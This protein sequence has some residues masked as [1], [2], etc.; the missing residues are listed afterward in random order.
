MDLILFTILFLAFFLLGETLARFWQPA[1]SHGLERL[2]FHTLLGL[3][4]VSGVTTALAFAGL[5]YPVT[6]WIV[7]AVIFLASAKTW[8]LLWQEVSALRPGLG[9][10][11]GKEQ[12][13]REFLGFCGLVLAALVVLAL[14]L[15][16]APP[17]KTDALVYH[18]ALPKAYLENHGIINLP[19]S[20][21]SF[22]PLLFEMV[23]LFALTFG[24][25]SLPALCGLGM[26]FLLLL[27][28]MVY[29]RQY[30]SP[31]LAGFVP[32]L[33]F[34]TP[35]FFE[36]SASAYVDLAL[37]GFMFFTFYSW[38]RWRETRL[39]F[40]FFYMAGCAGAAWATKLT[41]L[42][43]LPLAVLGIALTGRADNNPTRVVKQIL[44]FGGI[45]F[46][47][48]AP[49]WM[50]NFLYSGNPLLPLLMPLLGGEDRVNWDAERALMFD[51]YV[52]LFGM[53]RGVWD[54][55][56]LP[57]NLTFH[58][59]PDSLKFDGRIGIVFFLLIPALIAGL[60]KPRSPRVA[61]LGVFAGVLLLFWFVYFQYVRFLAP[62]FTAL[63]L[64]CVAG[65][66]RATRPISPDDN[67]LSRVLKK[68]L[69]GMVAC[70]IL[71]NLSLIWETWHKK[72]P[73]LFVA[74][75]E[76]RDA[77]LSRNIPR[78]PMYQAMNGLDPKTKVLL[79]Y[80]RN[81][82]Y[83]AERPF[84]SDSVF[85]AHTLQAM[86]ARDASPEGLLG[87]FQSLG[88]T[89]LM[90]DRNFVF[91]KD[92]AFSPAGRSALNRFLEN[93]ARLVKQS[94]DFFLYRLVLD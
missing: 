94:G 42:I 65:L 33:F 82:G 6:G 30:L 35:T 34:C 16:L 39:P 78:Y 10:F 61:A 58:A 23:F 46:L 55:M 41:G 59:E 21:Y 29:C 40:W 17:V 15:A 93:R 50:R 14:I 76:T 26:A 62:A 53:G 90:F 68:V 64:L 47:F 44:I 85:E 75:Q 25:E 49:W 52:K 89:H 38:D 7:L 72:N 80:M 20:M 19:N 63:T 12:P 48:M 9:T 91:G 60:W 3:V 8:P 69:L 45:V 22:F 1:Y 74:G 24:V 32:V 36:I 79:V 92:A 28:L 5:I 73:G 87:Q 18:L 11:F 57:Y 81:L 4:T 67:A 27:G 71:F 56:L 66:E 86:L 37:A 31:R 51:Q 83:L 77:Y 88:I 43:V 54:L 70:G 84:H 13:D 2:V